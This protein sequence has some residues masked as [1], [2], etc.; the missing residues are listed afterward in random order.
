MDNIENAIEFLTGSKTA[1]VTFTN[2]RHITRIKKLYAEREDEFEDF[3][4]NK[5]GSVCARI[6]LKWIRIN[7]GKES[8]VLT[9]EQKEAV[10]ARF[11]KARQDKVN[12]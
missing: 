2:R 6:P 3:I 8:R 10:V 9:D 4:Q 7:P 5:D 1:T 12:N 11:A